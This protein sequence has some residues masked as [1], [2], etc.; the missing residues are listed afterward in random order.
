VHATRLLAALFLCA[1]A[2]ACTYHVLDQ[3]IAE[4]RFRP[5]PA[6]FAAPGH[7]AVL[8]Y[9]GV[10]GWG[11][12]WKDT[13]V[14]AAPYFSNHDLLASSIDG[15]DRDEAAIRAGFAGTPYPKTNVILVGHG[16]IDHASDIPGYP[17]DEMEVREPTLVADESTVN[18]LGDET[19]ERVCE[20]PLDATS[21]GEALPR[22]GDCPTGDVRIRPVPWAHAP[23]GQLS[24][25]LFVTVGDPQG[26][27]R[28]PLHAPPRQGKDWMIGR[29]WAYVID[30]MDRGR[31]VFRIHYVD[32][33]AN[34]L[35]ADDGD[36]AEPVDVHIGCIPGF[37]AVQHYP[38]ELLAQYD[39]GFVLG[40]HWENFFQSRDDALEPV[41]FVLSD[42]EMGRFVLEVEAVLGKEPRGRGPINKDGC[43]VGENCGPKGG[44]WAVPIPGETFWFRTA[45]SPAPKP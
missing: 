15:A 14:L 10:G 26:V 45:S 36:D 23:H 2:S 22:G 29:T 38:K 27:Q 32:A 40:G 6:D 8:H 43:K 41:P 35:F 34:P 42:D 19:R 30:L 16:H 5:S 25:L 21:G 24:D 18:L 39:V 1:L 3:P 33:A 37:D 20:I 12:R 4:H 28:E 17:F 13:Y 11:I 31:S 7:V 44:R 9:Y